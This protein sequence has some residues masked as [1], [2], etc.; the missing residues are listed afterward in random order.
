MSQPHSEAI[1]ELAAALAAAQGEFPDIPKDCTAKVTT[2][3]GGSYEFKYADLETIFRTVRPVL[4]KHGLAISVSV[5]A[6]EIELPPEQNRPAKTLGM[7]ATATLLH[8]SGQWLRSA[9]LCVPVDPDALRR[10]YAQAC[11]SAAT[12]ASRYVIEALLAIR[13]TED[14]DGNGASGNTADIDK[15][16]PPKPKPAPPPKPPAPTVPTLHK[17]LADLLVEFAW[18]KEQKR[19]FADKLFQPY[20]VTL[21]KLVADQGKAEGVRQGIEAEVKALMQDDSLLTDRADALQ[22]L[23]SRRMEGG[24]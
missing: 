8:T 13:A 10:Q 7:A 24:A 1:G 5:E 2:R 9:P 23:F 11:G 16:P 18:P 19:E 20:E 3:T 15:L 17:P 14:D 21:A 4:A 22:V 6:R 12:Y